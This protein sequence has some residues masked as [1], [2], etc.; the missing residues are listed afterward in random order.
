MDQDLC[1]R[2]ADIRRRPDAAALAKWGR[3]PEIIAVSK[4]RPR[5][6]STRS[7]Q[8]ELRASAKTAQET[9]ENC[10]IW[11]RIFKLISSDGCKSTRLNI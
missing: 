6:A 8:S 4:R 9:L 10:R 2:V 3:A 1:A 7:E 11:M 5:R